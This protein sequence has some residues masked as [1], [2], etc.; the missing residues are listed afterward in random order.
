MLFFL[1]TLAY[2]FVKQNSRGDR[3]IQRFDFPKHRNF[4]QIVAFFPYNT[5]D[6]FPFVSNHDS[7]RSR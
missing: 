2:R 1:Q 4:N 5:A 3:S 6:A 7:E